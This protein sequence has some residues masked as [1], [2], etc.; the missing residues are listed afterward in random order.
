MQIICGQ[1]GHS[2]ADFYDMN[3]RESY[4]CII[5][6]NELEQQRAET[7]R[8]LIFSAARF[9]AAATANSPKQAKAI[10]RHKFDWEKPSGAKRK[11][12][13]SGD[14]IGQFLNSIAKPDEP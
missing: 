6:H 10:N 14:E 1:I 5:G 3:L 2:P 4:N 12:K 7:L 9:N 8:D 13:M 11:K